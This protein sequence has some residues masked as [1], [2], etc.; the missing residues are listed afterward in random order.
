MLDRIKKDYGYFDFVLD[1]IAGKAKDFQEIVKS[2]IYNKLTD[3]ISINQIPN[4]YPEEAF[5]YLGL[6]ETPAERTFYR[7]IERLGDKFVFVLERHQQFLVK[8]N[9]VSKEQF[10]DFSSTYFEGTKPELGALGYS[11]DGAP[12]KK[13]ITF[14][15]STGIN[16]IPTALTIQKGNVQDKT[17]FDHIFNVAKKVLEKGSILIFDC[18]ANTKTNKKMV[19]K[20]KYHYLTLKAKKKNSYRSIIQFFLQEKKKGNIVRFEMND[21]IYECV[22]LVKDNETNYIFFSEKLYQEQLQKREKKYQRLLEK[23]DKDLK[24]VKK[25]KNLGSVI[26]KDGYIILHGSIQKTLA[27]ISNPFINGLEGFFAL[28]SSVDDEPE[29]IL[30][31]YKD[32]DK[33]EKFIRGLKDGLELRPIRHWSDLAVKGYLLLTFLTNFLV[34]LTLYLAKKPIVKDIRL[35]RKFLNN[36]TLTVAYP[37][38]AFKFTVLSNISNEV[39]SILGDFIQKYDDNSLKLRW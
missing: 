38:N 20:G 10:V 5:E 4:I 29:K 34:N 11:R 27:P 25:G 31:L 9:L 23:N 36:L 1:K 13:Q 15:I 35:L 6:D 21:S 26:T 32:R 30:S 14:G 7:T 18:G 8:N 39:I 24:K 33:A 12:G 3:N 16:N 19:R 22:K 37:P 2:L 17:H 28:E